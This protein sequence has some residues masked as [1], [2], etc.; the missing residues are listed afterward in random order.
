MIL[1]DYKGADLFDELVDERGRIRPYYRGVADK[2]S[3]LG[4]DE[5]SQ[6]L[7]SLEL[8]F[9]ILA[10]VAAAITAVALLLPSGERGVE[11]APTALRPAPAE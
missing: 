8:L 3:G 7:R 2:L 11:A 5:L 1:S 6:K 9:L 4:H 10:G